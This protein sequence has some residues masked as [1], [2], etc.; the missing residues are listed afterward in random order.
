[1][2]AFIAALPMY[3]WPE[4]RAETNA[5]WTLL[6]DALHR[7]GVD[8]PEALTRE[9]APE[10]G[11]DLATLWRHPALLFAQTCWGP[12]RQGL[13]DHVQVIG[14]PDYSAFEGGQG[15]LYSSAVVMRRDEAPPSGPPAGGLEGGVR[16]S[17]DGSAVLPLDRLRGK[18]FAFN[19][20]DSMSGILA[21][22]DDL[23]AIGESIG[24]F[25]GRIESGG[26]RAS[27]VAVAEGRADVA[28]IDC[29]SW[30]MARR[31]EPAAK[32][33]AVVGWTARRK[34]LPYVCARALPPET[35][36]ALRA[37]VAETAML[38]SP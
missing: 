19:S 2:S 3:D 34:G 10:G 32:Q 29:R 24:I 12:M 13:A 21:L 30:A 14:Q 33:V 36:A 16:A 5:Q 38:A 23:E 25:S 18:R 7:R 28:A 31:F 22:T 37:A 15:A 27:I 26:H 20:A 17:A 9:N 1:M 11:L 6:R 4:V 8:A 35:V